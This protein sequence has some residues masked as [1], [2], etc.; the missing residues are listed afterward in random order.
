RKAGMMNTTGIKR[1]LISPQRKRQILRIRAE[2]REKF[3]FLSKDSV[4]LIANKKR[5][6]A[7]ASEELMK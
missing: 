6:I 1:Y 5:L 7:I 2:P 4:V 3:S